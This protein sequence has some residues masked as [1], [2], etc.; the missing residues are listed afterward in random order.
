MKKTTLK[1]ALI[2]TIFGLSTFSAMATAPQ[3]DSVATVIGIT[4][5]TAFSGCWVTSTAIGLTNPDSVMERGLC[6]GT[7]ANPTIA[8]MKFMAYKS[9]PGSSYEPVVIAGLAAGTAYHVRAY[10]T[11][12]GGETG[13]ST[14]KLFTTSSNDVESVWTLKSNLVA[15]VTGTSATDLD[16]SKVCTGVSY[17]QN[18]GGNGTTSVLFPTPTGLLKE[19][20]GL[21]TLAT[22]DSNIYFA[23]SVTTTNKIIINQLVFTAF[24]YKSGAMNVKIDY[25]FDN[26]ATAG[27]LLTDAAFNDLVKTQITTADVNFPSANPGLTTSMGKENVCWPA[28]I[29]ANAGQT[30]S[31]R[32]YLWGKAGSGILM[33]NLIVSGMTD[34]GAAVNQVSSNVSNIRLIGQNIVLGETSDVN[35][36][37]TNGA[38]VISAKQVNE[39]SASGLSKGIYIVKAGNSIQKI[40]IK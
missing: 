37:N 34:L 4:R 22:F 3:V 25:S 17:D 12:L 6:V 40:A 26:F 38:K 13:Y 7:A 10:A 30:V 16:Y 35:V 23:F 9:V 39:V 36:Y 33:K 19:T 15:D 29:S 21:M 2:A 28:N 5:T 18:S 20:A 8:D 1:M 11:T 31:F 24:G 32:M 27:T 14:E